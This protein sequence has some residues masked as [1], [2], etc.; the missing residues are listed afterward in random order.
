MIRP[1]G[2]RV[3][4]ER[5]VPENATE[6]G[7]E[8]LPSGLIIPRHAKHNHPSK[9]Y[10]AVPDYFWARVIGVGDDVPD[11]APGDEVLVYSFDEAGTGGLYTGI[12]LDTCR[13]PRLPLEGQRLLVTYPD[14]IV[15]ALVTDIPCPANA[16][17]T[18]E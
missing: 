11:L 13:K 9:K 6:H 4:V 17:G 5:V 1:L 10:G 12:D 14:D 2:K 18:G 15:C 3:A 16:V 8:I 7:E